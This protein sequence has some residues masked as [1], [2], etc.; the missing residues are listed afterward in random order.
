VKLRDTVSRLSIDPRKLTDYALDPASLKG[1]DKA[2]M[3]RRHLG[4]TQENFQ[5][6]LAQIE[7]QALDAEATLG[8]EDH[9]GQRFQVDLAIMGVNPGQQEIV[10]TGWIVKPGEDMARLTTLYVRRRG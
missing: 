6:L 7:A 3:F 10:R 9:H 2:A 5:L 4:F 1:A 8:F